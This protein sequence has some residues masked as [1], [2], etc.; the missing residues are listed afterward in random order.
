MFSYLHADTL[1]STNSK[2]ENVLLFPSITRQR[3][4]YGVGVGSS[5]RFVPE[6]RALATT[7]LATDISGRGGDDKKLKDFLI[8]ELQYFSPS[9]HWLCY[10]NARSLGAECKGLL[11]KTAS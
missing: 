7:G 11:G 2:A 3:R 8:D 1:G 9:L 4:D 10:E 6:Q 5:D